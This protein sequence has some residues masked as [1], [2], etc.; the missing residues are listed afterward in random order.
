MSALKVGAA[1]RKLATRKQELAEV[2]GQAR[3]AGA[4]DSLLSAWVIAAG[5]T[6]EDLVQE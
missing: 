4:D 5:L 3:A 2:I 1:Q 6:P